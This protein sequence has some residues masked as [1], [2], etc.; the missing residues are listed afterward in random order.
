M[1]LQPHLQ[2]KQVISQEP[3]ERRGGKHRALVPGVLPRTELLPG[4]SPSLWLSATFTTIVSPPAGY[5]E[6]ERIL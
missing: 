4:G 5:S 1:D 6:M 3:E 2:R